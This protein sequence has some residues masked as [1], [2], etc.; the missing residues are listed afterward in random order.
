M[1]DFNSPAAGVPGQALQSIFGRM[2]RH[3]GQQ[4]PFHGWQVG[5]W[6]GFDGPNRPNLDLWQ[7]FLAPIPRG[8][9]ADFTP[10]DRQAGRAPRLSLLWRN[11]RNIFNFKYR[12]RDSWFNRP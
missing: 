9:Q 7:L 11:R 3:R 6:G 4:Q 1:P 2:N 12:F 8:A 5:G 10:M